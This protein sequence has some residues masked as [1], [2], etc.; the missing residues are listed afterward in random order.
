MVLRGSKRR[1]K[2]VVTSCRERIFTVIGKRERKMEYIQVAS[3]G[4]I[5]SNT[6]KTVT[7]YTGTI[8]LRSL[9]LHLLSQCCRQT[10]QHYTHTVEWLRRS[11]QNSALIFRQLTTAHCMLAQKVK[12]RLRGKEVV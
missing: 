4:Y 6:Q 5:V 3:Q 2:F 10:P 1:G 8:H 7:L 11:L 9:L 12:A